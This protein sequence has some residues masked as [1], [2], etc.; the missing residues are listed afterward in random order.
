MNSTTTAS[1]AASPSSASAGASPG[2]KR[3]MLASFLQQYGIIIAFFLLCIILTFTSEYF[4]TTKNILN[5]LRQTSINGILAMGMTLVVLT[6]GIDLSVGSVLALAGIVA[7]SLSTGDNPQ[8]ALVAVSAGIGVGLACGLV[9]GLVVARL[10]VPPFVATL[11]MLSVARGLTYIYSDGMPIG[12]LSSPFLALGQ[13]RIFGVPVPVYIFALVFVCLWVL[14]NKTTFGR[15]IY[16][17]GGNEK[18]ARTAGIGTRKIIVSVYALAGLLAGLSG[19]VLTARTT[20]GLPQAGM[21]YELDAIAAVVIG[22]T[23]LNG[24]VGTV[25]GTLFGALIIGVINN[26]L[27]LMGVSSFYQQVVKGCIIVCA[28]L[29]DPARRTRD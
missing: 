28:V 1:T 14:L 8:P 2:S 15:Y 10:A 3:R 18:S 19:L 21:S 27:D 6:K 29:L 22:G 9:N 11:G 16:A 25:R 17:V 13:E 5:V 26:G 4:L 24:G 20:A 7:A 23:S 12:N